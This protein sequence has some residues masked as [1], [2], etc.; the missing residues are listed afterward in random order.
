M[1]DT[2]NISLALGGGGARGI[3][4]VHVLKAFDDLGVRPRQIASSSIGSIVGAGY[5]SGMSGANIEDYFL[6]TF[7]NRTAAL[8]KLWKARPDPMR[9]LVSSNKSTAAFGQ[10][11]VEKI[12]EVFLPKDMARDF[13]TLSIP[14][15]ITATDYYGNN[16]K[17]L[18]TG[19]LRKAIAASA[20]IP[21]VFMPVIIDD[22]VLIDGG[23]I[24]PLP[25]DLL[26]SRNKTVAVDVVGLPR[27]EQ[28][29]LPGRIDLGF[30]ASQL[31]MQSITN[32]KLAASPPDLFLRPNVDAFRVLDFLKVKEILEATKPIYNDT[33]IG[34]EKLLG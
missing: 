15:K 16:L 32:I 30:G 27:G 14:L 13:E 33:K 18:E 2:T 23:I 7:S 5:A 21:V 26:D 17:I 19:D 9:A 1:P 4:H 24:N 20:A 29:T 22:C 31:L 6:Q 8:G 12:L 25:F 11:D 3:A 28:G 10:M 34:L